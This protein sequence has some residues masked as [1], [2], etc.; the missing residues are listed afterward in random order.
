MSKD[1]DARV[2]VRVNAQL[3][4]PCTG[5][6]TSFSPI[7]EDPREPRVDSLRLLNATLERGVYE[8]TFKRVGDE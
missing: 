3:A 6:M 7:F 2:F 4:S 8:I 5:Y 1:W